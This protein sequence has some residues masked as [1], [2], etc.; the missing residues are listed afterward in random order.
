MLKPNSTYKMSKQTK[1]TLA[2]TGFK[3]KE[4]RDGW[5]R[6]MIDAELCSKI[7]VKTDKR[8]RNAPRGAPGVS[9]TTG[10]HAYTTPQA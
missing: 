4:Q 2:L 9:G 6:A 7:V 3:S 8:D 1:R 5:K 10:S